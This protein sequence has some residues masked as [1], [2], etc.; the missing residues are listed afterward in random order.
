MMAFGEVMAH[1]C[2]I[3]ANYGGR[4]YEKLPEAAGSNGLMMMMVRPGRGLDP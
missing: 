4:W 3:S 1:G 2:A